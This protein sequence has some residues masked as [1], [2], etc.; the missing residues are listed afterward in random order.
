MNI[1]FETYGCTLNSGEAQKMMS[2]ADGAGHTVVPLEDSADMVVLLTCTVIEPTERKILRRLQSIKSSPTKIVVSGCMAAVQKDTIEAAAPGAVIIP[3]PGQVE[4]FADYLRTLEKEVERS[5]PVQTENKYLQDASAPV[6]IAEGCRGSCTYCIT[7]L[8]RGELK[9]YSERTILGEIEE[10]VNDG[11]CEIRLTAQDS[12][13][14]A[15]DTG[16][17][18]GLPE[19][20]DKISNLKIKQPEDNDFK[21]RIGMMNPDSV[22]PH[23]DQLIEVYSHPRVFKFL[24]LPVQSGSAEILK[25]MERKYSPEQFISIVER[26]RIAHP[27]MTL[28]TDI[29]AGFPGE[30]MDDHKASLELLERIRPDIVNVTRFSARPGTP[31]E[32][33]TDK[34]HGRDIKARSRELTELSS[35]ISLEKNEALTGKKF[36]V[37]A[38]ERDIGQYKNTTLARTSEYKP[39]VINETLELGQ[40]YRVEIITAITA[41]LKAELI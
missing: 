31:A 34:L 16:G 8:A 33:M 26:F 14:Y 22:E 11:A 7:R 20:L 10:A 40:L 21:V 39:V 38:T 37:M 41:Y 2:A 32:S 30:S 6:A 23:L 12:A 19:L 3:T 15:A 17:S 9:S 4:T 5:S 35:K 18:S 36:E 24:H 13:L 25:T 29:I 1:Y 28:S 27:G